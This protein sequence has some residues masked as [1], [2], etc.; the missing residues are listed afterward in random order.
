MSE[1]VSFKGLYKNIVYKDKKNGFTYFRVK[2]LDRISFKDNHGMVFCQGVLPDYNE[3]FPLELNGHYDYET[4]KFIV[5]NYVETNVDKVIMRDFLSGIPGVGSVISKNIV[6]KIDDVFEL[7]K[8][9]NAIEV[10]ENIGVQTNVAKN[11]ISTLNG[12]IKKRETMQYIYTHGGDYSD[13]MKLCKKYEN[14]IEALKCNPYKVGREINLPLSVMDIIAKEQNNSF[15]SGKRMG[16]ILEKAVKQIATCGN[17]YTNMYTFKQSILSILK[18]G[19]YN[20]Y[21]DI[22]FLTEKLKSSVFT[23]I[24]DNNIFIRNLYN[25]E[26]RIAKNIK[27]LQDSAIPLDINSDVIDEI[28]KEIGMKYAPQQRGCFNAL[29]SSGIKIVIGGPGTGKTTT[30]NGLLRAINKRYPEKIIKSFAPTGRAAQRMTESTGRESTTIHKGVE[31]QPYGVN[32][33][34][35]GRNSENYIDADVIVVDEMSMAEEEIFDYLLE[36]AKDG[37]LIILVGDTNQLE[38]VGPGQVLADLINSGC[39]D[40]YALTDVY[41]QKGDSPIIY[42]AYAINN[43][44]TELIENEYF[45]ITRCVTEETMLDIIKSEVIAN[46]KKDTPFY[47]QILSPTHKGIAGVDNINKTIQEIVNPKKIGDKELVYGNIRF[48]VND[49]I[50]MTQNNYSKGYC[51]GD[52][53]TVLD[54]TTDSLNVLIQRNEIEITSDLLCDIDLAYANTIHKSQGSEYPVTII[55]LPDKPECML[56]RNLLYT[57]VTR[58]KEKVIIV[59]GENAIY[60]SIKTC[61]KGTRKT[62]LMKRIQTLFK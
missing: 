15:C 56:K 50:I 20:E 4:K 57:G 24:E 60:T 1:S 36:A 12:N 32:G 42:N 38:S 13:A 53:G 8:K 19:K 16:F 27:R 7:A 35:V 31:I 49:K 21:P 23:V 41:R 39:I 29:K 34:M 55:S 28:E 5:S 22:S 18:N 58:A 30:I 61:N 52:I 46:Y 26:I 47:C 59:S 54:V 6:S 44:N 43:G 51:N 37:T 40:V 3:G 9:E 25:A 10:L 33:T 2:S 11:I 45:K 48:R 17:S 62:M 14:P